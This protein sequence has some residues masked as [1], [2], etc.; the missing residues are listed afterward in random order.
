MVQNIAGRKKAKIKEL[1]CLTGTLNFLCR[2][3]HPGQTF[4]RR[5][6]QKFANITNG[7]GKPLK[8][9]H[10]IKLDAEF[11]SD[12]NIWQL[13]LENAS[14]ASITRPFI[15]FTDKN[16]QFTAEVLNFY[17]DASAN[18]DLGMGCY[19]D[20]RWTFA[21]WE[22]GFVEEFRPS[23]EYLE[24]FA[25]CTGIFTW[26]DKLQNIRIVIHCD[27]QVVIHMVNTGV[28][29]CR[30]CMYL[31]RLL[32][33]N[34]LLW[35]RRVFVIYVSSKNNNLSDCLSRMKIQEFFDAAPSYTNPQP[36]KLPEE[37]WPMSKIWLR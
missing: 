22:Q 28:S 34:N 13:F 9:Y 23:I 5:M 21:Q 16:N 14:S 19:Y 1:Q 2:I 25:L 6:Y 7:K 4:T 10:H 8:H 18:P 35:N 31:L 30:Q 20:S 27:N 26:K 15:D 36:D 24:L 3:L 12:C 33:L 29:S 32:T 11:K 17:T 37:L